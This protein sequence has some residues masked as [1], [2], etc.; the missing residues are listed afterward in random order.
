M[1]RLLIVDDEKF[2]REGMANLI[3]WNKYG[4]ELA[5]TAWNGIEGLQIIEK[6]RPEIV[7]TD[8][9]MPVLDGIGLIKKAKVNFPEIEFIV[10]S[11]YGE[12]EFTSQAM[13]QGV[14]HYILKPCDEEKIVQVLDKVKSELN[15]KKQKQQMEKQYRN[16]M[17]TLLP[18]AKEQLF[19]NM[20][21][22]REQIKTEYQLFLEE[23]GEENICVAVLAF[24]SQNSFDYLEQFILWNILQELSGE[25]NI[26]LCTSVREDVLFLLTEKSLSAMENAVD[27]TMQEFE[28]FGKKEVWAAISKVGKMDEVNK[29]YIQIEELFCINKLNQEKGI[30][31]YGTL[32]NIQ[33]DATALVNYKALKESIDYEQVLFELYLIFVKMD[34]KGYSYNEKAELCRW[35]LKILYGSD[36]LDTDN[37]KIGKVYAGTEED[38]SRKLMICLTDIII[39]K[40]G[41]PC[42]RR[43]EEEKY[44]NMLTVI[45][46]YLADPEMNIQYLAK[47]ILFMNEDYF[48][49]VFTRNRKEKFSSY[50]LNTR[51]TI[52]KRLMQYDAEI[53]ISQLAVLT[54]FSADGQYFSK[55][56]K[57]ATGMTPT[58]FKEKI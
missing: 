17:N 34:L 35:A 54:G 22:G 23:I 19:R 2:E 55:A 11:G 58:E 18:R 43:K 44:R 33:S 3:P 31:H 7:I 24:R 30:L 32:N 26:L 51:I 49:R 25:D 15:T 41:Y 39:E 50:L 53:K 10:L 36:E 27:R 4:V 37:E 12:Y 56:F 28:K 57:K 38:K 6:E 52:A 29:L 47:N 20:L 16:T 13:E 14:R 5:G 42:V 45:Y 21:L 40:K 8:I 1:Y 46:Q 9:K 48:G